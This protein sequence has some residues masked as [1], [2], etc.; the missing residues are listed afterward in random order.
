[1]GRASL[2]SPRGGETNGTAP[3]GRLPPDVD[4]DTKG[5]PEGPAP[6]SGASHQ[7]RRARDLE[8]M[9]AVSQGDTLALDELLRTYWKPLVAQ[10]HSMVGDADAAEDLVQEV[11]L[12]VWRH[13]RRW[14]GHGSVRAYLY[15]VVR[16]LTLNEVRRRRRF[17]RF[18]ERWGGL[19]Q[20]TP[21]TPAEVAAGSALE[22]EAR[23]AVDTLPPRRREVF[24]LARF[25]G[26]SYR[27]IAETMGISTQTVANQMSAAL[28]DLGKALAPYLKGVAEE[29]AGESK[30][31]RLLPA[32]P[33]DDGPR[34]P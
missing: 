25:H 4:L 27:E 20:H 34:K 15:R 30:V 22:S 31:I 11:F 33:K 7:D 10:A 21:P 28:E 6:L 12:R 9:Q 17:A 24:I 14:R 1:M 2:S 13:R 26:L 32:D 5:A 23:E 19:P 8:L 18:R 16:N 29:G 3:E